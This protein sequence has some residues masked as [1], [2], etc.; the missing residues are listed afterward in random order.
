MTIHAI[1]L[2]GLENTAKSFRNELSALMFGATATRPTGAR[3]GVRYGTPT[4]TVSLSGFDG[5]IK[6]HAGIMDIQTSATAGPYIYAV[7][8][9]ENFT[10]NAAHS[11]L[12]RVDIVTVRINDDVEDSSGL[13]SATVHYKAGTAAGSPVAPTPDTTR[14]MIIATIAVPGSG[15]GDPAVSWVAPYAVAGGG[16]IPVRNNT[17]RDALHS[18]YPGTTDAPLVVWVKSTAK[19]QYNSSSGWTDLVDLS[20]LEE[21]TGVKDYRWANT[22]ARTAQTGMSVGDRGVQT[23]T[24]ADYRYDGATWRRTPGVIASGTFTTQSAVDI[25]VLSGYDVYR[26]TFDVPT[27][28]TANDISA[29]LR[30]GG[31]TIS[32]TNYD[33][34]A[35]VAAATT[36]AASQGYGQSSWGLGGGN[37]ADKTVVIELHRL[38]EAVR[39]VGFARFAGKNSGADGLRVDRSL[40]YTAS[41]AAD[42]I[43]FTFSSGTGT[44]VWRAEGIA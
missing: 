32:A 7:T 16:I 22:A 34:E 36:P 6:P 2:T 4:N 38:N 41:T 28:S 12:A 31:S 35:D 17:E 37:R 39:T 44:G 40:W 25:D 24:G 27:A 19:F 3:S 26:I 43:R 20:A 18:A 1:A 5:T 21:A 29:Q 14:E 30:S 10:V 23:D 9:D 11:T 33:T 15:G 8:A 42:G 13:E